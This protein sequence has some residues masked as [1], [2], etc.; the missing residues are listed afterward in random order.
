MSRAPAN[1]ASKSNCRH[2]A[3]FALGSQ[4]VP[5][6]STVDRQVQRAVSELGWRCRPPEQVVAHE[7]AELAHQPGV[8]DLGGTP[9][10]AL[11]AGEARVEGVV[12]EDLGVVAEG[13]PRQVAQRQAD[14]VERE[15]TEGLAATAF[16]YLANIRFFGLDDPVGAG[17]PLRQLLGYDNLPAELREEAERLLE[18]IEASS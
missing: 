5:E 3:R 7:G 4:P 13:L 6:L 15:R 16:W 18:E 8:V 14:P 9:G 2:A 17:E 1:A 10:V 12:G 11:H